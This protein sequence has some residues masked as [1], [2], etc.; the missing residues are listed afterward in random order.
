MK[1]TTV[2]T[3]CNIAFVNAAYYQP[4]SEDNCEG[5]QAGEHIEDTL[6]HNTD[7]ANSFKYFGGFFNCEVYESKDCSGEAKQFSSDDSGGCG[8]IDGATIGSIRCNVAN[9]R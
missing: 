7:N 6:C 4:F 1:F 3:L 5:T 9:H 2:I 8:S